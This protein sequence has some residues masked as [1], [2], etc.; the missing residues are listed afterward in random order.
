MMKKLLG[1]LFVVMLLAGTAL[2]EGD[3]WALYAFTD[4]EPYLLGSAVATSDGVLLSADG[5]IMDGMYVYAARM[6]QEVSVTHAIGLESGMLAVYA[7]GVNGTLPEAAPAVPDTVYVHS[8]ARGGL[9]QAKA[10][11]E[12]SVLWHGVRCPLIRCSE[13]LLPG[14][15]VNYATTAI[16]LILVGL[17]GS[18]I[19]V[20]AASEVLDCLELKLQR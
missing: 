17:L 4:N 18:S 11:V 7:D 6:G 20:L 2:A 14:A 9:L 12:T 3:V 19:P 10:S 8:A 5:V 1:I 13:T 16:L 15:L